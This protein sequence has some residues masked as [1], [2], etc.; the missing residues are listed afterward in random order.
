MQRV[1]AYQRD[2]QLRRSFNE[3]A[4]EVF[5]LDFEPWYRTG[6][7]DTAYRPFSLVDDGRIVANVSATLMDLTLCGT[8]VKAVQLG[9]VMT[10]PAYRGQGLARSLMA[11]VLSAYE[12]T[13]AFCFLYANESVLSFYPRFGFLRAQET[14]TQVDVIKSAI[15]VGEGP[16]AYR[17]NMDAEADRIMLER[18]IR[19]A[20]PSSPYLSFQNGAWLAMFY[21][22]S[23]LRRAVWYVPAC[24]G[25]A[26]LETGD[27]RARLWDLYSDR[28]VPLRDWLAHLPLNGVERLDLGFTP[29]DEEGVCLCRE[30]SREPLFLL[31]LASGHTVLP[32]IEGLSF[33]AL[34]HT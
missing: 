3:L 21:C 24:R 14:E 33:P 20:H 12:E 4:Q 8:H 27:D 31:P 10:H 15:P 18:H 26:I 16:A 29:G 25:I 23:P 1:T 9:T 5:G 11:W 22:L 28:Y 17:L 7:W 32:D 13:C 30:P 19:A 6:Y 34:C 2:D